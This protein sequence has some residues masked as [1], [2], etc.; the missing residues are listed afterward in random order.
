[1]KLKGTLKIVVALTGIFA[2]LSAVGGSTVTAAAS[3]PQRPIKY[4]FF[5]ITDGSLGNWNFSSAEVHLTYYSTVGNS[6]FYP[7]IPA[8][9]ATNPNRVQ[10]NVWVNDGG[11]TT[12]TIKSQGRTVTANL[13]DGQNFVSIDQWGGGVGLGTWT[14]AGPMPIYPIGI[15]DGIPDCIIGDGDCGNPS[16]DTWA[17]PVDLVSTTM[18]SGRAH[19]DGCYPD[20]S[21]DG[22]PLKTTG[23]GDLFI[24]RPYGSNDPEIIGIFRA[25]LEVGK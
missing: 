17:L 10:K 21:C 13:V 2:T 11:H 20:G 15:Q 16:A 3:S 23:S 24:A 5:M 19:S 14:A 25:T 12:V 9:S 8:P 1:M 22:V 7:T 18:M 4:D 6:T